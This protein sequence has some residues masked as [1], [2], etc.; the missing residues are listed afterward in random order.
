LRCLDLVFYLHNIIQFFWVVEGIFLFQ[1]TYV[2]NIL[3]PF[4]LND[5]YPSYIPLVKGI[6]LMDEVDIELHLTQ[7]FNRQMVPQASSSY[8]HLVQ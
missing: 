8:P 2:I 1:C 7:F 3:D 4:D 6:E 5:N